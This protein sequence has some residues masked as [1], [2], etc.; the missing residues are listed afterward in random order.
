MMGRA[1][2]VTATAL[3]VE[4]YLQVRGMRA[5]AGVGLHRIAD[6]IDLLVT[7]VGAASCAYHLARCVRDYSLVIH[8]G[9]VG[10]Y[11]SEL[12]VGDLV[13]ME[14]DAF[15]NYGVW[16]SG[17][18]QSLRVAGF[19]QAVEPGPEG[20]AATNIPSPQPWQTFRR[21]R[22][23]TVETP[24]CVN[25][26]VDRIGQ[27]SPAVEGMEGAAFAMVCQAAELERGN[28]RSGSCFSYISLGVVSNYV[29][30]GQTA[31]W[32]VPLAKA[33]LAEALLAVEATSNAESEALAWAI[34]PCPNDTFLFG[35]LAMGL[36]DSPALASQPQL[37]DIAALNQ[38]A[39]GDT[40]PVV[41]V[42]AAAY[43]SIA[44]QYKILSVGAALGFGVGP[45]LVARAGQT[46]GPSYDA[47]VLLPGLSTTACALFRM[48]FPEV[49]HVEPALFSDIAPRVA[50]GEYDYGVL[51]HEGRFTFRDL[52]LTQVADLGEMWERR[53]AIPLPLGVICVQRS[54]PDAV[55]RDIATAIRRSLRYAWEHRER[56]MPYVRAHAQEL[57]H[58]VQSSH[59]NLYVNGYT[60]SLGSEGYA[61]VRTLLNLEGDDDRHFVEPWE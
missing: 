22:A 6:G 52:G 41:K 45:I 29:G 16:R 60:Y 49:N 58:S 59:I 55:Q 3:E 8:A 9:F 57:S 32:N 12:A 31:Q 46:A 40:V 35:A 21:V 34:S 7:G 18:W 4:H 11:S 26:P 54:L 33:R 56:V 17:E 5:D 43:P 20:F 36:I 19:A 10:A 61:A 14:S 15:A 38:L 42:S 28:A 13:V 51:I 44:H 27:T 53:H 47:R 50:S 30:D 1:L 24:G 37:L 23:T 48:F 39:Q 2:L 25:H